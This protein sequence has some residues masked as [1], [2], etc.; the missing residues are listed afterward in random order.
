MHFDCRLCQHRRKTRQLSHNAPLGEG[1]Q[2][3]PRNACSR[4]HPSVP[5]R[6]KE[7]RLNRTKES[8]IILDLH[9]IILIINKIVRTINK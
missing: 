5:G 9:R 1:L 7:K 8:L 3:A 2:L 4:K 6:R